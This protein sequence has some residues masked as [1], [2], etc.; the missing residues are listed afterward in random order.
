[1]ANLDESRK[2]S[3]RLGLSDRGTMDV[4]ART[5]DYTGEANRAIGKERA[6]CEQFSKARDLFRKLGYSPSGHD[7]HMLADLEEELAS[8]PGR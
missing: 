7:G 6:A 3:E 2:I 8:C 1:L 5:L 4:Y